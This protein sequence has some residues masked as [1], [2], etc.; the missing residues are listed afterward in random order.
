MDILH[1]DLFVFLIELV[2]RISGDLFFVLVRCMFAQ[3]VK[4][5]LTADQYWSLNGYP[6]TT[7]LV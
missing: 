1:T 7:D 5:K 6:L 2:G 3:L 4:E